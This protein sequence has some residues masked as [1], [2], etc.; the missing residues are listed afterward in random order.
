M[1][2]SRAKSSERLI[3]HILDQMDKGILYPKA[4][5]KAKDLKRKR[6]VDEDEEAARKYGAPDR[7]VPAHVGGIRPYM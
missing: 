5:D 6:D 7:I 2:R 1:P 3:A 4:K